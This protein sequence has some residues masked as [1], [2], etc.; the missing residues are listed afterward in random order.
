MVDL[1]FHQYF[2]LFQIYFIDISFKKLKNA[3]KIYLKTLRNPSSKDTVLGN[4]RPE[5]IHDHDHDQAKIIFVT[6]PSG[7]LMV[8]ECNSDTRLL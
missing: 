7:Q 3:Q 5:K 4:L 2:C 1:D 6:S 8:A